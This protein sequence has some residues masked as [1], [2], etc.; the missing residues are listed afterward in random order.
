MTHEDGEPIEKPYYNVTCAGANKT[1]KQLFIHSVEQD[2]DTENNP[3][4]YTPEELEFIREPRSIS[5]FVPGIMI[6]GKLSQKRI[7]GGV[8]LADTTF[9]MH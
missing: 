9:E 2:Y 7:K 1:V 8:I 3:E 5:D 6:P 4:N